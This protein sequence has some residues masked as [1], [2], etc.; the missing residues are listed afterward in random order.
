MVTNRL[1]P[2]VSK[3]VVSQS[4]KFL[5]LNAVLYRKVLSI[6]FSLDSFNKY[7]LTTYSVSDTGSFYQL[8]F[9]LLKTIVPHEFPL[10]MEGQMK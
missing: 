9:V 6:Y 7:L 4:L 5:L 1:L 2:P 10:S 8:C 3:L